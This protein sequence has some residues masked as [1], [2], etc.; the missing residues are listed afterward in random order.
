VPTEDLDASTEDLDHD[1]E[2]LDHDVEGPDDDEGGVSSE[3][4]R[5]RLVADATVQSETQEAHYRLPLPQSKPPGRWKSPLAVFTFMLAGVIAVVPPSWL[6]PD[7]PAT[8]TA[9]ERVRGVR[10]ALFLQAQQVEAYKAQNQRLPRSLGELPTRVPGVRF[11]RSNN[12]V[13]QLVAFTPDGRQMVYD[14]TRPSEFEAVPAGWFT[15][16]GT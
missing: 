10:A 11:V 5:A 13:Y 1:D 14:S 2:D 3:E 15:D 9:G 12:Q 4:D 7:A 6:R 8:V 16:E